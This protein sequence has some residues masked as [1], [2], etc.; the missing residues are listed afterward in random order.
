MSAYDDWKLATPPEYD[1]ED[2]PEQDEPDDV[3]DG[4]DDAADRAREQELVERGIV[5]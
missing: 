3:E 1:R 4:Y 5:P 2:E